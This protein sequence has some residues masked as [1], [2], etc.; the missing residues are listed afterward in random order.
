MD[1]LRFRYMNT[2]R[3]DQFDCDSGPISLGPTSLND[4]GSR[5]ADYVASRVW[6]GRVF[7]NCGRV[8]LY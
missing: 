2:W 3:S 7:F 6:S 8:I 5:N 4:L 1:G